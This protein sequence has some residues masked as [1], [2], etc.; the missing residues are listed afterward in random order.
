[1]HTI[2]IGVGSNLG[3]RQGTI[4]AALQRLRKIARVEAV[5]SYY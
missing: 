2:L 5:S 4:L 1:M 3:D